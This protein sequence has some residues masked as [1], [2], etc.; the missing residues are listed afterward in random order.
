MSTKRILPTA[1]AVG[2]IAALML[3]ACSHPAPTPT[4]APPTPVL[5]TSAKDIA[6]AWAPPTADFYIEF[7]EDGTVTGGDL[8]ANGNRIP[9]PG[10]NGTFWFEGTRL[11]IQEPK[12]SAEQSCEEGQLGIYEVQ[13]LASGKLLFVK[14]QDDC[15]W[16]VGALS[17]VLSKLP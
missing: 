17:V 14:I 16:R 1:L 13:L 15:V 12:S 4:A 6:G 10:G 7:N 8:L 3:T 2:L 9:G 11:T 5:A